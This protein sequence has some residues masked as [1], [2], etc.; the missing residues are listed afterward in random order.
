MRGLHRETREHLLGRWSGL[1]REAAAYALQAGEPETALAFLESGR[2]VLWTQMIENHAPLNDLRARHPELA[3]QMSAELA[4]IDGTNVHPPAVGGDTIAAANR[5]DQLVEAVRA[6]PGF[7]AFLIS[8]P[9]EGFVTGIEGPVVVINVDARR[10]DA[11]IV[12]STGLQTITLP[13]GSYDEIADHSHRYREA[14]TVLGDAVRGH[15]AKSAAKDDVSTVLSWLWFTVVEPILSD[16][17]FTETGPRRP[18]PR[19]WWCPTVPAV[20]ASTAR[21]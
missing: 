16:L 21:R 19:V 13:I 6:L 9:I 20:G 12:K 10:C 17:G 11:I 2:A 5:F 3:D 18:L 4:L 8:P 15:L 1:S 7:D 14:V